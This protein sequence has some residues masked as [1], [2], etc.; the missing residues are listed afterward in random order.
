MLPAEAVMFFVMLP[1]EDV[2]FF[3]MLPAGPVMLFVILAPPAVLI[4]LCAFAIFTVYSA[5]DAIAVSRIAAV[6]TNVVCLCIDPGRTEK[7]M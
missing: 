1:A 2:M 6:I 4:L 5:A 3:V 7:Y